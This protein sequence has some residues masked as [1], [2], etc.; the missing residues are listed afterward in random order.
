M[1]SEN[2][3]I[4][5]NDE[6]GKFI[7]EFF[8][9]L[10]SRYQNS[11]ESIKGNSFVFDHVHFLYYKCHKINSN[12]DGIY[13]DGPNWIKKSNNNLINEKDNKCFQ[14]AVTVALNDEEIKKIRNE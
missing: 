4:E 10:K 9:S 5:I 8:G 3:N 1:H 14:F 11:L 7:E 6:A 2:Y 13:I 12:C